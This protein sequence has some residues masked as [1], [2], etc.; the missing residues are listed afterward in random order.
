[1]SSHANVP[2]SK[3][4]D[5]APTTVDNGLPPAQITRLARGLT[6]HLLVDDVTPETDETGLAHV[7]ST[8][9]EQYV[10]DVETGVCSCPDA[11][12]RCKHTYRVEVALGRRS[13]PQW[14]ELEA[15]DDRLR[16]SLGL[17]E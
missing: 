5:L 15:V 16:E 4:S 10:V 1:M 13:L 6:E 7:Y 3:P 2:V 14:A 8:E 12:E 17:D 9:G 11:G